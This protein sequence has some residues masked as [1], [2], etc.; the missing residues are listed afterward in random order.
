[1]NV[2]ASKRDLLHL[3]T[4]MTAI[5][6]RKSTMPILATVLLRTDNGRL[7]LA[8]SDLYQ[9]LTGSVSAEVATPGAFAVPAKDFVERVKQMADGPIE[10]AVKD[11]SLSL[12]SKGTARR[13]TMR[14]IPGDDFP[15]LPKRD[16]DG[17]TFSIEPHLLA[18]VIAHTSFS[19]STDET[20][21]HLN[22][23]LLEWGDGLLR[24]VST[25]GH[26][27]SKCERK[28]E[29]HASAT[30]LLPLK[31]LREIQNMSDSLYADPSAEADG[32]KLTIAISGPSA[33][34]M[35]GN[36]TFTV[37][38]VDATFPPYAQVIPKDQ[39]Q[40]ARA[41]RALLAEAI[42]AVSIAA[43]EKGGGVKLSFGNG[44]LLLSSES[45]EKGDGTDE[46]P[47]D[48]TGPSMSIGVNAKYLLDVLGALTSEEVAIGMAGELDPLT[49]RPI[50][51]GEVDHDF[52]GVVMPMRLS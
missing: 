19:I 23:L 35:A 22:S 14:G 29:G 34:F 16:A 2:T 44:R 5:A 33:F 30:M 48:F 32:R 50:V 38:L 17:A 7:G 18:S 1:M 15:P 24:G 42:R 52:V 49:F 4:R 31:A 21:A 28:I 46:L 37:K 8:A 36:T 39:A 20:R 3:A 40:I 26:R 47:I 13:F 9:T 45:A 27:L 12:K 43:S 25:D 11:N 51:N 6:E 10:M 41:P